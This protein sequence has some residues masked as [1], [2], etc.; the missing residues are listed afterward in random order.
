MFSLSKSRSKRVIP[1]GWATTDSIQVFK[2]TQSSEPLFPG[3]R[4][5]AVDASGDLTLVG[6]SDG[7][8]GVFSIS[9]QHI[10]HTLKIGG[11]VTDG[12]WVGNR[13]VVSSS[14]GIV[15]VFEGDAEIA[16]FNSHSGEVTA[17]AAHPTGDIVGSVGVD[18]S[19]VLY[20]LV[21]MSP[22]AQIFGETS[23]SRFCG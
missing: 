17:L 18:K 23:R 7:V 10:I 9:K 16:S 8:A 19:Y 14:T 22:M 15:K 4:S 21:T 2:P 12:V 11:P 6:G 1:D 13:A 20:D 5:L 3:G